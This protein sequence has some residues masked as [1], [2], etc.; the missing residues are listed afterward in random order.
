[1]FRSVYGVMI[2]DKVV[3]K[4]FAFSMDEA[5]GMVQAKWGLGPD[6]KI[7]LWGRA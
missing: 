4:V 5:E 2:N 7:H 6:V 1:M 3:G